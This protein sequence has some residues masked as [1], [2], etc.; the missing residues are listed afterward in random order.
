MLLDIGTW[1]SLFRSSAA[2]YS[3]NGSRKGQHFST[4]CVSRAHSGSSCSIIVVCMCGDFPSAQVPPLFMT[5]GEYPVEPIKP[6]PAW[7]TASSRRETNPA[8]HGRAYLL[9]PPPSH[10]T[11]LGWEAL[12]CWLLV[13]AVLGFV[14]VNRVSERDQ[15]HD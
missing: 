7:H 10:L 1:D 4:A 6:V 11:S 13:L 5:E 9:E 15:E 8:S 12:P 3:A 2:Q 14:A